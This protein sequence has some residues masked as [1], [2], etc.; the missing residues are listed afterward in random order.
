MVKRIE[1]RHKDP[2][3]QKA[4][5]IYEDIY[6][7]Y[8]RKEEFHHKGATHFDYEALT[9]AWNYYLKLRKQIEGN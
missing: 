4:Y 6:S 8:N 5:E 9:T 3:L 7:R 1:R 2:E